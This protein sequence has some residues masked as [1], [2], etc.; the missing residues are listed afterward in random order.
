M[1]KLLFAFVVALSFVSCEDDTNLVN[2]PIDQVDPGDN[3]P[4]A[5]ILGRWIPEGFEDVVLYEFIEGDRFTM[6][7]TDG[8][9]PT[10]DDFRAEN[11]DIPSNEWSYEGDVLVIDLHFGN[12]SRVVPSFRCDNYVMDFISEDGSLHSTYFREGYDLA[13]CQ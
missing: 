7:S 4:E 12:Y 3:I 1:K 2:D 6:Y 13:D 8:N 10:L 11:P 9:F 5:T